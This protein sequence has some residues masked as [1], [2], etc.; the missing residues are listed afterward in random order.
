MGAK[1][2][3]I[4]PVLHFADPD[5]ALQ[6]LAETFGFREHA[7]H[8]DPEGRI[9]YAEMELGGAYLGFGGHTE[10]S[11][12]DLGAIALYVVLEDGAAIDAHHAHAVAAGAEIV[13]PPTRTTAHATTRRVTSRAT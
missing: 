11:P 2:V 9:A 13:M 7:V 3:E 12:F 6:F 8:R 1:N 5:K 10:G 4:H